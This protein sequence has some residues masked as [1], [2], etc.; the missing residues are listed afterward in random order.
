MKK[1]YKTNFLAKF[2]TKG[3]TTD[4]KKCITIS[5]LSS[6]QCSKIHTEPPLSSNRNSKNVP[7]KLNLTV[8]QI[9]ARSCYYSNKQKEHIK[10]LEIKN[11]KNKEN[12]V[13]KPKKQITPK[14][15]YKL[16]NFKKTRD[17]IQKPPKNE[18]IIV[19]K[20]E[21]PKP[22]IEKNKIKEIKVVITEEEDKTNN[23][24]DVIC[25]TEE[26]KVSNRITKVEFI[27]N[28]YRTLLAQMAL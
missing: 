9:T 20:K 2:L 14:S 19:N 21:K 3:N 8:K 24:N 17:K 1:Q 7:L 5:N 15:S 26:T 6:Y 18:N 28:K 10:E 4:C 23:M 13:K 22:K 11:K 12:S 25:K 27:K 16:I